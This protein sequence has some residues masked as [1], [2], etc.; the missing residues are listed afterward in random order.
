M[1]KCCGY[2]GIFDFPVGAQQFCCEKTD[3]NQPGCAEK[4][5]DDIK[6][7]ALELLI[8]PNAVVLGAELIFIIAVPFLIGRL[9][10]K[11]KEEK[12][13]PTY[14]GNKNVTFQ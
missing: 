14:S 8:I 3:L 5:V 7:N 13:T 1:F 12:Y 6:G 4:V 10:K 11:K 2:K 9:T